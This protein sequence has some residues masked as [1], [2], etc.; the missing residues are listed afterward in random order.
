MSVV[1]CIYVRT[2]TMYMDDN[3]GERVES[4]GVTSGRVVCIL[5][6]EVLTLLYIQ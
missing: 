1:V 5:L 2:F 3:L 4:M 6:Y